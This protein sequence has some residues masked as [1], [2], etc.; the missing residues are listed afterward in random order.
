MLSLCAKIFLF[1]RYALRKFQLSFSLDLLL[2]AG[3]LSINIRKTF[4]NKTRKD[5]TA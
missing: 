2:I 5:Q 1:A 3:G 4:S